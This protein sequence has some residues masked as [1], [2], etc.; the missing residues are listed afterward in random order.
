MEFSCV[1]CNLF[2]AVA[3]RVGKMI[4]QFRSCDISVSVRSALPGHPWHVSPSS[5]DSELHTWGSRAPVASGI[6]QGEP[7][8][9]CPKDGARLP[10]TSLTRISSIPRVV[11]LFWEKVSRVIPLT[12]VAFLVLFEESLP[13]F[14]VRTLI[15]C[16]LVGMLRFWVL[17]VGL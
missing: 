5:S 3:G 14:N 16:R 12:S 1:L 13:R 9:V 7:W 2:F 4:Y 10:L 8:S 15:L 11:F 6:Q 17:H